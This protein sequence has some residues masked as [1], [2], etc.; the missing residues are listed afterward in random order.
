MNRKSYIQ[1]NPE[2]ELLFGLS[3]I[4]FRNVLPKKSQFRDLSSNNCG[5]FWQLWESYQDDF[6]N[7]C[8][9]WMGGNSHDAEDVLNQAMLKACNEWTKQINKII[10][11]QSWLKQIIYNFCMDLH[12]K[13]KREAKV[14]ENIEDIEFADHPGFASQLEIPET[15]ILNLEMGAYLYHQIESLPERLR[16][17]FILHCCQD[18]SYQD[19]AKQLALS[20]ENVRKR[21]QQAREILK[22]QLNSYLAG[23]DNTPIDSLSSSL[24]NVIPIMEEFQSN[25]TMICNWESSIPTKTQQEE[26]N[27]QVAVI[28]LESLPHHWYGSPNSLG[29]R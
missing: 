23:E 28:C 19:V 2:Q 20:E 25:E 4:E 29:Y 9:K 13:R 26:I 16:Y 24:K 14:I 3:E 12:R 10:Y 22:K 6:Y 1:A 15:N 11:P 17:P 8:L 7:L 18:K 5:D 21:I 27:Y